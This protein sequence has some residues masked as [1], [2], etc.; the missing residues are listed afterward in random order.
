MFQD[1]LGF[2]TS[3]QSVSELTHAQVFTSFPF[4]SV[5]PSPFLPPILLRPGTEPHP[6]PRQRTCLYC[7]CYLKYLAI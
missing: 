5:F 7:Y 2:E 1:E 4:T 6:N 3:R